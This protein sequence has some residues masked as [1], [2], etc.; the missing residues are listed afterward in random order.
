LS[1]DKLVKKKKS[2]VKELIDRQEEELTFKP[3]I[4]KNPDYFNKEIKREGL[5]KDMREVW[6]KREEERLKKEQEEIEKN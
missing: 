3:K 1:F 6:K 4:N 5:F 2:V